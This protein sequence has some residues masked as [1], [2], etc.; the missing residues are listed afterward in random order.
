MPS[1]RI[2]TRVS[3][4][5]IARSAGR[6]T[7]SIWS[8]K[9]CEVSCSIFTC[10]N[11][12]CC[13]V[14]RAQSAKPRLE[15][16]RLAHLIAANGNVGPTDSP[17]ALWGTC[18]SMSAIMSSRSAAAFNAATSP[19]LYGVDPRFPARGL[20]QPIEQLVRT[21]R[22]QRR[23]GARLARDAARLHDPPGR[24]AGDP[25]L[26]Q[27]GRCVLCTPNATAAVNH[28]ASGPHAPNI[29]I[30]P[31]LCMPSPPVPQRLQTA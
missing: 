23:H 11:S 4:S 21:R 17:C 14:P 7:R 30:T 26:L 31:V 12:R 13:Q 8:E 10:G 9:N 3:S 22:I 16:G 5:S 2:T 6:S 25:V 24:P 27:A 15:R 1:C 29:A 19:G 20:Q 28:D 18:R